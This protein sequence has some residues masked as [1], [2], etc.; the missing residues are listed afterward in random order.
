MT[1]F[2]ERFRLGGMKDIPTSLSYMAPA[3]DRLEPILG[4]GDDGGDVFVLRF[5]KASTSLFKKREVEGEI[6]HVYWRVR[7]KKIS[8]FALMSI[9]IDFAGTAFASGNGSAYHFAW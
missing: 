8:K 4:V 5:L 3:G 6:Q 1:P 7:T 9:L 2:V